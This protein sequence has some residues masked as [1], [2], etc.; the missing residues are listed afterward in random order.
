[1]TIR[2]M[3]LNLSIVIAALLFACNSGNRQNQA[4]TQDGSPLSSESITDVVSESDDANDQ[5]IAEVENKTVPENNRKTKFAYVDYPNVDIKPL[6]NG[7]AGG[8]EFQKYS[9]ENNNFSKIAKKNN[10]KEGKVYY[11]F[12]IDIDGSVIDVEIRQ[13]T[14]QV[15]SDE[16]LRIIDAF[17]ETG[18]W[19]PGRHEGE[20]VKVRLVAPFLI[21]SKE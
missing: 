20:V 7:K 17:N 21:V 11:Q 18:K 5:E 19:T 13:S 8:E 6:F 15:F 9:M 10:I 12:F 4:T 2:K 3:Q 1:M 16:M 14:H